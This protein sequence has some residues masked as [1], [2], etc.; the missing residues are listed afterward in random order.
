METKE[1]PFKCQYCEQRFDKSGNRKVHERIHTGEKPYKCQYCEK[2]FSQAG[3]K[4]RH[5]RTHTGEKPHKCQYCEKTFINCDTDNGM[6]GNI[7]VKYVTNVS[8]VRRGSV[9]QETRKV[10]K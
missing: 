7:L 6:K 5:E 9:W 2:G 10:L 8:I 1:K 3:D 4:K